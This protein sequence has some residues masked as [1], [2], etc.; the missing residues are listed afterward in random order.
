MQQNPP[1]HL[2]LARQVIR[3][4]G[5]VAYP[6]EAVFG[7][8]CHPL[9]REAVYR[10]LALKKRPVEKGLIL[11]SDCFERLQPFLQPLPAERTEALMASWPGPATWLVPAAAAT[12]DW[13]TGRHPTLAVRVTAHPL[14]SALCRA[15]G[16]PLVSTSANLSGRPPARTPLEVRMRCGTGVDLVIHGSTGDQS[17]PTVIR[18]AISG[19]LIRA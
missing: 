6:T 8:G 18:D 14:A 13:L 9:D 17:R 7:L 19:A 2:R 1:W 10:L 4:G 3:T 11:I 5:L 16:T 12:P 15:A